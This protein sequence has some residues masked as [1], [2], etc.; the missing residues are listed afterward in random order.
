MAGN[1][2]D[3]W[4]WVSL[5]NCSSESSP[6]TLLS[7]QVVRWPHGVLHQ[8]RVFTRGNC[9]TFWSSFSAWL[10]PLTNFVQQIVAAILKTPGFCLGSVLLCWKLPFHLPEMSSAFS[11]HIPMP[12]AGPRKLLIL[13]EVRD[14][15][16]QA[17]PLL[18]EFS[19]STAPC[20][21]P[22]STLSRMAASPTR[23]WEGQGP[24]FRTS[25]SPARTTVP[26]T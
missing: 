9:G 25:V 24:C 3:P 8:R 21:Y 7:L 13:G 17:S 16:A 22:V 4:P 5:E 11:P 14:N 20:R 10:P 6:A 1:L 18:A 12:P 19:V 15:C 23:R 26:G 2:N